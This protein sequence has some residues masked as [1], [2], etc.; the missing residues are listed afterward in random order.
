[1]AIVVIDDEAVIGLSC[2]R[3]LVPEGYDVEPCEDPDDVAV[4]HRHRLPECQRRHR[5]REGCREHRGFGQAHRGN[6]DDGEADEPARHGAG[7]SSRVNES[8]R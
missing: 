2:R 1:M 5:R 4:K 3:A 6:H 7:Y 8:S